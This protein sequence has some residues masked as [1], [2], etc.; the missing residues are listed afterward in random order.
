MARLFALNA[1]FI[2][3]GRAFVKAASAYFKKYEKN[4][5]RDGVDAF[6]L[7]YQ[8]EEKN[9]SRATRPKRV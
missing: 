1:G 2:G 7:R 5:F 9:F 6:F 8:A 4:V 3:A